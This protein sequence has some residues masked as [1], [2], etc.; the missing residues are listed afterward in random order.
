MSKLRINNTTLFV[1]VLGACLGLV[2]AG[3]SSQARQTASSVLSEIAYR[4]SATIS[5]RR[6]SNKSLKRTAVYN[7]PSWSFAAQSEYRAAAILYRN[8]NPLT[9]SNHILVVTSLARA[10]LDDATA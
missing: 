5:Y 7:S 3:A 4:S 8:P 6:A 9:A 1:T 2:A 10:S